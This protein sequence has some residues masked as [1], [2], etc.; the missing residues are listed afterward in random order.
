MCEY[1]IP[2]HEKFRHKNMCHWKQCVQESYYR[3]GAPMSTYL[4]RSTEL[5]YKTAAM[6]IFLIPF[7]KLLIFS[8][9]QFSPVSS[10][11]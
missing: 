3:G 2:F 7:E 1:T 5:F 9:Q 6:K 11:F 8:R 10:S 4:F